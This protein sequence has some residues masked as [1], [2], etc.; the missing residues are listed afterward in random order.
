V[1]P[2]P[3]N[4]NLA[5]Y[6]SV[7][8]RGGVDGADPHGLVLMLMDAALQRIALARG[9]I[10]RGE[11]ARKAKL[12]HSSVTIVAELRGCL[13][14]AEGGALAQNLSDL[15]GYMMHRLL[16]GNVN[17]D[18]ACLTEVSGLMGNIREAWF[19]IAAQ[20]R[21]PAQGTVAAAWTGTASPVAMMSH[22]RA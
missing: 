5:T 6:H 13:K 9:C 10:E 3:R 4:S 18:I 11:I 8:V 2:F 22:S 17:S 15:Y 21:K 14:M 20:V 19:A 12:L 7:S 1:N 16:L